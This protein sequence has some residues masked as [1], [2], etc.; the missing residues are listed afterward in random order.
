MS[1]EELE[2]LKARERELANELQR[3]KLEREVLEVK[4]RSELN[5]VVTANSVTEGAVILAISEI[6][7]DILKILRE[8]PGRYYDY[9][10]SV[11]QIPLESWRKFH[12]QLIILPKID[13]AYKN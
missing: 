8:T 10:K 3:L 5:V 1:Q 6:R 2:K 7:D 11:N 13:F 9:S 12:E 4:I